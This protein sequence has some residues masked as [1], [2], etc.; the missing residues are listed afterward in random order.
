METTLTPHNQTSPLVPIRSTEFAIGMA[1]VMA[2][3]IASLFSAGSLPFD[4]SDC[5]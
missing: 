4:E 3:T 2:A 1:D 5:P